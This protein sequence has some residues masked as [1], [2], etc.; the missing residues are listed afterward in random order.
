[1][2]QKLKILSKMESE[3]KQTKS[4]IKQL[5]KVNEKLSIKALRFTV[6]KRCIELKRQ[7]DEVVAKFFQ[8]WREQTQRI[9]TETVEKV[10]FENPVGLYLNELQSYLQKHPKK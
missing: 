2:E 4:K 1:M 5:K 6:F 9:A 8:H 3:N 7:Q 10:E